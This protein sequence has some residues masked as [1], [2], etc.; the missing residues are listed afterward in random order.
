MTSDTSFPEP[1]AD[2]TWL[3]EVVGFDPL[4]ERVHE[5]W[6]AV[7]NGRT[8]TRGSLEEGS[9]DSMPATY[10]AGVFG[11]GSRG[12]RLINGIEWTRL[13][14]RVGDEPLVMERGEL[15]EHRRILD[16]RT[17]VLFRFWRQRL[18]SGEEVLFR[19]ARW[20]S[21]ADRPVLVLE[22]A[23]ETR[24][25]S[26][27]LSDRLRPPPRSDD[28]ERAVVR[29]R[30]GRVVATV[31]GRDG[32][33]AS[34]A[35]ETEEHRGEL[36]RVVGVAR[37]G[38]GEPDRLAEAE[39][40]L[41]AACR[42][43]VDELRRRHC[44][45]WEARWRD[46]EIVLEHDRQ[47]QEAIR[48][49]EHHLISSGDSETDAY[50]IGARGLTGP[51]YAGHVF[52]DTEVFVLP[53]FIHTHPAT[54][55]A[56]LAYRHRTLPAA[57]ERARS[58]GYRGALFA[59]E[60]ADTGEETTPTEVLDPDGRVVPIFTGAQEHHIVADVA[61]A[62]WRYW[63]GTGDDA[64]MAEMGAELVLDTARFWSSRARRGS[65]G[66]YHILRV[67]GPDEYHVGVRDNAF[68]NVMARWNLERGLELAGQ[69]EGA[70]SA[71]WRSLMRRLGLTRHELE[72]WEAAAAGLVTGFD[73][74]TGL[75]EQF[76]GFFALEDVRIAE[77]GERPLAA[78]MLLGARR[79]EHAQIV[80]QAD[81]LMLLHM[82]PELASAEVAEANYAYYEPRTSHG[83]SLSPPIHAAL[84]ARLGRP[85][86][87][88]DYARMAAE[89][90]LGN[91]MGN[92]AHGIHVAS[93]GALWQAMAF[94]F[95]GVR[96]DGSTLRIDPNLP[97]GC[98]RLAFPM[99]WR[100]ARVEIEVAGSELTCSF[101]RPMQV[102]IG[103][104]PAA[105]LGRGRYRSRMADGRWSRPEEVHS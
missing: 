62:A 71:L 86:Q 60:S 45:A 28:V 15:V 33:A 41:G 14:P 94:G 54:A 102:A 77:L 82:L 2:P 25:S 34:F 63:Q 84:A 76:D 55:R 61:W 101:D 10:V 104:G 87:A 3:L 42:I 35:I 96:S 36:R 20:A 19:S 7:A 30:D 49:A 88:L 24:S 23:V 92:A 58:L 75:Y 26:I 91:G 93:M 50:S 47:I 4:R 97:P 5:S 29:P 8:G 52:W 51:G 65:D 1:S 6:F 16:L 38:F 44:R 48:F 80:K 78:D 22:A 99:L 43:G 59:W 105:V 103:E 31:R 46:A 12:R 53:F 27:R 69:L 72:R 66:R 79:V 17:G 81:V 68:T 21:L 40:A 90:D 37:A 73:P 64:F 100:G 57:R 9:D 95:G 98:A 18:P 89:V 67:I 11:S 39:E 85:S 70:D 74:Q 13:A 83:S 56:L 32:G